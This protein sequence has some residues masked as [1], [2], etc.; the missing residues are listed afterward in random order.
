MVRSK[1]A[2]EEAEEFTAVAIHDQHHST[3]R[4]AD[5]G[6]I[7]MEQTRRLPSGVLEVQCRPGKKAFREMHWRAGERER[8]KRMKRVGEAI[9]TELIRRELQQETNGVS[10]PFKAHFLA[11]KINFNL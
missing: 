1:E 2:A 4:K 11:L 9:A 5:D 3:M 7:E 6:S 10:M 8:E